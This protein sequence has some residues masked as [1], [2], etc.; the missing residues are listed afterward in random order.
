[1]AGGILL[2]SIHLV[3]KKCRKTPRSPPPRDLRTNTKENHQP[4]E[5]YTLR[6]FSPGFL[7]TILQHI[8]A[9]TQRRVRAPCASCERVT[10]R[11]RF[12]INSDEHDAEHGVRSEPGQPLAPEPATSQGRPRPDNQPKKNSDVM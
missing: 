8:N 4:D 9:K 10:E 6:K 7:D 11:L 12:R 1:M 3:T 2:V 5:S